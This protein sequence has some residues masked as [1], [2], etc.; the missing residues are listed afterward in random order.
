MIKFFWEHSKKWLATSV[1]LTIFKGVA[2]I[3]SLWLTKELINSITSNLQTNNSDYMQVFLLLCAQ[4]LL[5]IIVASLQKIQQ[6]MDRHEIT[7]LSLKLNQLYLR[8]TTTVPLN[9]FDD[10]ELHNYVNRLQGD[11]GESFLSPYQDLL[12]VCKSVIT[13]F[14]F[15]IFLL[16]FHWALFILSII[17]ALPIYFVQSKFGNKK[18]EL[19]KSQTTNLREM[20]YINYLLSDRHSAKEIRIYELGAYFIN[21]WSSIFSMN[22]VRRLNLFRKQ[23]IS[24][25]GAEGVTSLLYM[26]SALIIIWLASETTIQ[27]GDFVAIGQ[28]VQGTQNMINQAAFS[29]AR[30]YEKSLYI[31]DYFEFIDFEFG[32]ND[33]VPRVEEF[34]IPL[35]KGI[36]FRNVTFR[37][38]N[39]TKVIL[40]DI[41]F[42]I[43]HGEKIAIVGE[44]GSGKSTLVKCLMGLYPITSGKI[45]FDNVDA[46]LITHASLRK[47]I[48]A[49]FQDF[50]KYPFSVKDNIVFGDIERATDT[51][52]IK[53]VACA[54]GVDE[55]VGKFEN[56]YET[57]LGNFL[58]KGEDLSGGQW[59]KIALSR[60]LY[61][62]CQILILDEPTAALDPKSE[63][64][65]YMG[66]EKIAKNKTTIF[67]TH[68]MSTARLADRIFV[69][70]NGRI[71]E[72]GSHDELMLLEK[73]YYRMYKMQ[74]HWYSSNKVF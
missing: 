48:T 62:D 64:D 35:K 55:F 57:I 54:T 46:E 61:R 38:S 21:R 63:K 11:K 26:L 15:L 14:S 72:E 65:V 44:N 53:K 18:F 27:I 16:S 12:E 22:A 39:N 50:S 59:Q 9:A 7:K 51:F 10:P 20:N 52:L 33:L 58:E 8:K 45:Y 2:P 28:A 47:N 17:S 69:M 73:E 5:S 1:I 3:I 74:T 34:P 60:A 66:F 19:I 29:L 32:N 36:R 31:K 68:R 71:I 37:Y 24:E 25:V 13:I 67:I 30:I 41:S 23:Q 42:S 6:Y 4:F 40:N 70:K 49:I 43:R 56:G